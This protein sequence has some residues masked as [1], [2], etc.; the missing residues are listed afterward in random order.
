M[1]KLKLYK[2]IIG[3]I[4]KIVKAYNKEDAVRKFG[5]AGWKAYRFKIVK[6]KN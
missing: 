2:V 3:N 4:N 5:I 1:G 6:I